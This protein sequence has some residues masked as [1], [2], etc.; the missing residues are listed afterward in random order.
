MVKSHS[1]E[2]RGRLRSIPKITHRYYAPTRNL[3]VDMI[4]LSGEKAITSATR[5]MSHDI[6][7][8][9]AFIGL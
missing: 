2:P 4:R 1:H 6:D 7:R 9:L 3:S 5:S 8:V